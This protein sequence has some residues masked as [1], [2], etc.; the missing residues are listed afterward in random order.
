MDKQLL[1]TIQSGKAHPSTSFW[2]SDD[3]SNEFQTVSD[4][5]STEKS[6]GHKSDHL[7]A[8]LFPMIDQRNKVPVRRA[9]IS[10]PNCFRWSINGKKCRSEERS[11]DCQ[12]VSDDWSTEKSAGHKSDHLPAKLFPMIDQR[13]KVPVRRAI[14]SPPNRF[15]WSIIGTPNCFRWSLKWIS[16]CFRWSIIGNSLAGSWSLFWPALFSVDRA[17]EK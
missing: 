16:N 9:I 12:T 6:A 14:I 1:P 15:R 3:R 4:D 7:P 10:P 5:R 13:K 2:R 11:S 8:K 17:S